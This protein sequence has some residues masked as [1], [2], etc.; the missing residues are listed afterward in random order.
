MTLPRSQRTCPFRSGTNKS[1]TGER[2][3]WINSLLQAFRGRSCSVGFAFSM[4]VDIMIAPEVE[5]D[6]S[7]AYAWYEA[8]RYGLGEEFMGC[9]DVYC[10]LLGLK[11]SPFRRNCFE[12][13][14]LFQH[15]RMLKEG[16]R[17]RQWR[18]I[19]AMGVERIRCS[20]FT[21][22]WS[23]ARSTGIRC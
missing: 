2:P 15:G 11:P 8:R 5:I 7:E 20:R 17:K 21:I 23:G 1:W 10:L 18:T 13:R 6:M 14:F 12:L 19:A 4:A 9:V 16:R 22:M 3:T